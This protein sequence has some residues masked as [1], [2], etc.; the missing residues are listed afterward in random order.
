MPRD[1]KTKVINYSQQ[2]ASDYG[3]DES[4]DN[5]DFVAND[6]AHIEKPRKRLAAAAVVFDDTPQIASHKRLVEQMKALIREFGGLPEELQDCMVEG[7]IGS[8]EK[9]K[10]KFK[11]HFHTRV[12]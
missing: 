3:E 4:M 9:Y 1:A 2:D 10:D 12:D 6:D 7:V 8:Y 5:E 11:A